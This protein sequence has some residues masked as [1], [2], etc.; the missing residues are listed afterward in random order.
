MWKNCCRGKLSIDG[1]IIWRMCFVC[2]M[3]KATGAQPEYKILLLLK[4]QYFYANALQFFICRSVCSVTVLE[5][6]LVWTE[7]IECTA[8]SRW[9]LSSVP[10]IASFRTLGAIV[11]CTRH[12]KAG[13]V[14]WFTNYFKLTFWLVKQVCFS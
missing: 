7:R 8:R 12:H 9:Y 13:G 6:G 5:V 14:K 1:C 2:R 11:P 4:F 10:T 3:T